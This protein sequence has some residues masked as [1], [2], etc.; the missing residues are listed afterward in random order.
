MDA[1]FRL[2]AE[3]RLRFLEGLPTHLLQSELVSF[4]NKEIKQHL[5]SDS[6]CQGIQDALKTIRRAIIRMEDLR[7]AHPDLPAHVID[8]NRLLELAEEVEALYQKHWEYYRYQSRLS[9]EDLV[10]ILLDIDRIGYHWDMFLSRLSAVSDLT[11]A[12]EGAKGGHDSA[13]FRVSYQRPQPHQFSVNTLTQVAGFLECAYRFVCAVKSLDSQAYPLALLQVEVSDPV[14]IQLSVPNAVESLFRRFLQY[15]FL[16]DMLKRESLLKVVFEAIGKDSGNESDLPTP[17]V[18]AF[19][20]ELTAHLK[21]LPSDGR[22]II[23]NRTFPD[24]RIAVLQEF[25]AS[26]DDKNIHYEKLMGEGK[27]DKK[28]ASSK[29]AV[30]KETAEPPLLN[31]KPSEAASPDPGALAAPPLVKKPEERLT[32]DT[33]VPSSAEHQDAGGDVYSSSSFSKGH[34]SLLTEKRNR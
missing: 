25:T 6:F 27:G 31:L 22:F 12:L 1:R 19:T 29:K 4:V 13:V 9:E 15:L 3:I 10:R 30:A 24:D 21:N 16:H 26:L 7:E 34:I 20:K 28:S 11:H 32:I 18:T 8:L 17:L 14:D 23:S 5:F 33:P 2:Y